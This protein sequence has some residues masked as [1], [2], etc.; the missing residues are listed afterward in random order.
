[1]YVKVDLEAVPPEVSLVDPGDCTRFDVTVHGP[2]DADDLDR[3]LVAASVGRT[4]ESGA[5]VSVAAV[6]RLAAGSVG[7]RWDGDFLSM[8][9]YARG[10]G[11]LTEDA[12]SIRAHVQ[13]GL[14]STDQQTVEQ[15]E[16]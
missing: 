1:M 4:D 10:R 8:L 12:E 3:A 14:T 15:T 2:G 7:D 11:W 6:R 16:R 9:E 5:L 13:W